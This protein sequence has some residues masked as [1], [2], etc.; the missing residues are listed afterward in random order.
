VRRILVTS[1]RMPTAIDEIR[2]L[3]RAGHAVIAADT[4][5]SAPGAH[6]RFAQATVVVP[7]PRYATEAFVRGI[8]EAVETHAADLVVPCFE[9][10]LYLARARARLPARAHYAFPSFDTLSMLHDKHRV[11]ELARDLGVR[12]PHSIVVA[13]AQDLANAALEF[14]DYFAKP[15]CSRGGVVALTNKGP[16]AGARDVDLCP[17]SD[18]D[19]WVVEEYIDG[20]DVCSF[21][22]AV[23]GRVTA[24]VSYV[25]PR[26]IE[27][28]GGTVFESIDDPAT[29]E[30][31]RRFVESTGYEGQIS[32]DFRKNERGL[33][34]IECNPRPTA[35]VHL[36]SGQVFVDALLSPPNGHTILVPAGVRAKYSF[37]LLRDMFLH[38]GEAASDLKYLFSNAPDAILEADDPWPAAFQVMSG[39]LARAYRRRH[40]FAKKRSTDLMA[41]YFDDISWNGEQE[42]SAREAPRLA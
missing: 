1:C 39:G 9:E 18:T 40:N 8:A 26:E 22:V 17:P 10:S 12:A 35:G 3:G 32:F 23:R 29:L 38:V 34:L 42:A 15:L 25:H 37:G 5:K 6:S 36:M 31:A 13:S 4:F 21:S 30:V 33:H 27:H 2:K 7:S 20:I 11:L 14:E 24:H 41:A 16:L 19:R 28:A